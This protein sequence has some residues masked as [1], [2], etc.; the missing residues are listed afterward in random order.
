M[1]TWA[2]VD[3]HSRIPISSLAYTDAI[4]KRTAHSNFKRKVHP[5]DPTKKLYPE[6]SEKFETGQWDIREIHRKPKPILIQPKE[7]QLQ[8]KFESFKD[9]IQKNT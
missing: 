2:I 3:Y 9:F 5:K 8:L 7:Q 1:A 4:D 6:F